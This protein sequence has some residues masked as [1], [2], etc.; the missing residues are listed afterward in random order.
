MDGPVARG[1]LW[2][3]EETLFYWFEIFSSCNP[4]GWL[5]IFEKLV[6]GILYAF[7]SKRKCVADRLREPSHFVPN[8][9]FTTE[10]HCLRRDAV[11]IACA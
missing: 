11:C 9:I 5:N 3:F 8:A 7:G 6:F 10:Q 4:V 2:S 1:R